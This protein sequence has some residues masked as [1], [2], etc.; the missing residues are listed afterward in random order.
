MV[1]FFFPVLNPRLDSR[2]GSVTCRCD[3]AHS[4]NSY[5]TNSSLDLSLCLVLISAFIP[6]HPLIPCCVLF[7]VGELYIERKL[8]YSPTWFF[9]FFRIVVQYNQEKREIR[10]SASL[11]SL[12]NSSSR[13]LIIIYRLSSELS[14][15]WIV[16]C[17]LLRWK[18]VID[19]PFH[20]FSSVT[21]IVTGVQCWESDRQQILCY[22]LLLRYQFPVSIFILYT[23]R[24]MWESHDEKLGKRWRNHDLE[25][26]CTPSALVLLSNTR[27]LLTRFPWPLSL[28]FRFIKQHF[29][30]AT[31]KFL[32]IS[33]CYHFVWVFLLS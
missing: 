23:C 28:E 9:S 33:L 17:P 32:S 26:Q 18:R 1:L 13:S 15:K 3:V 30:L 10:W 24:I 6:R 12:L 8:T 11:P 7:V 4:T 25:E 14:A 21:F 2:V 27:T 19:C 31:W 22:S 20:C 5:A 16:S 29:F